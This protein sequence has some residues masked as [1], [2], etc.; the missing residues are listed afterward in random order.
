[1]EYW[2]ILTTD[3]SFIG[4]SR[5]LDW[6]S[7]IEIERISI[8]VW[9]KIQIFISYQDTGISCKIKAF[10]SVYLA[11]HTR[12]YDVIFIHS[13]KIDQIFWVIDMAFDAD[14]VIVLQKMKKQ[15]VCYGISYKKGN[16][17]SYQMFFNMCVFFWFLAEFII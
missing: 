11:G 1:M 2:Y 17:E 7:M 5:K 6:R 15:V 9:K 13:Q 16:A 4:K 8:H 12:N 10:I 14:I 3:K